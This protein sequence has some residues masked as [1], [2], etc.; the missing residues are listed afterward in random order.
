MPRCTHPGCNRLVHVGD[1]MCKEHEHTWS[2]RPDRTPQLTSDAIRAMREMV[3]D[4]Y[5]PPS[6]RPFLSPSYVTVSDLRDAYPHLVRYSDDD[7]T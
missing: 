7:P 2:D 5:G 3:L 6:F 4:K 1:V